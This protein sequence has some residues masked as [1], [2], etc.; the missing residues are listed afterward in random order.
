MYKLEF[1]LKQHTPII[2]FQHDQDGATLRATEVKPKLDRF[3]IEKLQLTEMVQKGG[4]VVEVSKQIYK[5]WFNSEDHLSLDYKLKIEPNT[6]EQINIE[7]R[8]KNSPMYFANMGNKPEE[9]AKYKHFKFTENEITCS[10]FSFNSKKIQEINL[11]K[12]IEDNIY[13]FFF[14]NNFGTRQSKGYGSFEVVKLNGVIIDKKPKKEDFNYL[15]TLNNTSDWETALFQVS[16]F[17]KALRSGI[18]LIDKQNY[19]NPRNVNNEY[20]LDLNTTSKYYIKPLI[21]LFAK[22]NNEQWDKK[23]IKQTYLDSNVI[24]KFNSS[25]N[26][27]LQ[28][29]QKH[30][31]TEDYVNRNKKD[32][33]VNEIGLQ[34]QISK[35]NSP[36]VLVFTSSIGANG[37]YYDFKD[38][39]GL[40]SEE[41]W[42]SYDKTIIKENVRKSSKSNLIL[43]KKK[44]DDDYIERFKSPLIFKLIKE[45]NSYNVYII[46]EDL[47]KEYIGSKYSVFPKNTGSKLVLEIPNFSMTNL[48]DFIKDNSL[49]KISDYLPTLKKYTGNNYREKE[50]YEEL[51][52]INSII[53]SFLT[54]IQSQANNVK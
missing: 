51:E 9:I 39:F 22:S 30:Y 45:E 7:D 50:K 46:F 11:L 37:C 21:F 53:R 47:P 12:A 33:F 38:L 4:K 48:F 28:F 49:F 20:Y 27:K 1:T 54:Q 17:Y 19:T 34:T 36:D 29:I 15:I 14:L 43:N 32:F 41:S 52:I 10:I 18:N 31:L 16:Y 25:G 6:S 42:K 8:H 2:H 5:S 13:R 24:R 40:A 23:T 26:E 44:K 3:L 35:H